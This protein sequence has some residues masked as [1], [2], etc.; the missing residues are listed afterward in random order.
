LGTGLALARATRLGIRLVF[1]GGAPRTR[2]GFFD[3]A[4]FEFGFE[5]PLIRIAIS[6]REKIGKA[7]ES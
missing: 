4:F 2:P 6:A 7:V 1:F 5:P 3:L